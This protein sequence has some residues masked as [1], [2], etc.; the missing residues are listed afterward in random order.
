MK[1]IKWNLKTAIAIWTSEC[2]I[3][4]PLL[5][6]RIGSSS[7]SKDFCH[8]FCVNFCLWRSV[9]IYVNMHPSCIL[10]CISI[11]AISVYCSLNNKCVKRK[12][13]MKCVK[14]L[15]GHKTK[16]LYKSRLCW[17]FEWLFKWTTQI[18]TK[19][20]HRLLQNE[21]FHYRWISK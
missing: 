15:L 8:L 21:I 3:L 20:R 12:F 19:K 18:N 16:M 2:G 5:V 4:L 11:H 10:I 6:W 7:N 9:R 13:V 14:V 1:A 17:N